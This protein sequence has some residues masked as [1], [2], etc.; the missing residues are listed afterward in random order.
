MATTYQAGKKVGQVDVH[1][2]KPVGGGIASAIGGIIGLF[3]LFGIIG[4]LLK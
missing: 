1:E 2:A 4:A 3:F